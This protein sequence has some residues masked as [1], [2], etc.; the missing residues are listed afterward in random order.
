MNQ[1]IFNGHLAVKNQNF[2]VCNLFTLVGLKFERQLSIVNIVLI[3]I[4]R[5][6]ISSSDSSLRIIEMETIPEA[7]SS[8][9]G[10]VQTG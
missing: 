7:N 6:N 9:S 8:L 2:V 10:K 4:V 1:L 3:N 5:T